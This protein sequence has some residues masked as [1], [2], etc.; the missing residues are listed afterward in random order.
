[1]VQFTSIAQANP[2]V[3]LTQAASTHCTTYTVHACGKA[4]DS[5]QHEQGQAP[6]YHDLYV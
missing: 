6:V 2:M 5:A 1:M 4:T 3:Q